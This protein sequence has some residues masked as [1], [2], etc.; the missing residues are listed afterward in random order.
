MV[1]A[2][3]LGRGRGEAVPCYFSTMTRS[4][5]T[6]AAGRETKEARE[7]RPRQGRESQGK[8]R[9]G[10]RAAGAGARTGLGVECGY[11]ANNL[12]RDQRHATKFTGARLRSE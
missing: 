10:V 6:S 8:Y 7:R 3:T 11:S 2:E 4:Q 12:D 9:D 5:D 1:Q